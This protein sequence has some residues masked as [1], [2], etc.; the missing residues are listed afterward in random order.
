MVLGRGFGSIKCVVYGCDPR[1]WVVVIDASILLCLGD[2][3]IEEGQC[4][5]LLPRLFWFVH[6]V[7]VLNVLNVPERAPATAYGS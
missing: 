1:K 6:P 2:Y 7:V 5:L 3:G 4:R